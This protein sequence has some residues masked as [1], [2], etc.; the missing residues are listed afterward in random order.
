MKTALLVAASLA[1]GPASVVAFSPAAGQCGTI[2]CAATPTSLAAVAGA[3]KSAED[4]IEKTLKIIMSSLDDDESGI[5]DSDDGSDGESPAPAAPAAA[6]S[7]VEL[8]SVDYDAAA[9]I[10]FESAGSSG[11]FGAFK[12]SYLEETSVMVSNREATA[13][14]YG[15]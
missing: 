1:A 7:G 15:K 9:M 2:A 10:A 13:S 11:D 3:A 8:W 4:D 5:D 6:S 14:F 12:A